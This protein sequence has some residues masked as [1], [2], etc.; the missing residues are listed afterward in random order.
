MK[1]ELTKMVL[2]F[3][4]KSSH[5]EKVIHAVMEWVYKQ[6]RYVPTWE[7][8]DY[9]DFLAFFYTKIPRL[10]ERYQY[11]GKPFEAYL[12]STMRWQI[13]NF[14]IRLQKNRQA[15]TGI[16][17]YME[18]EDLYQQP[19]MIA[20]PEQLSEKYQLQ[21]GL[22]RT[23]NITK[24]GQ[25]HKQCWQKRIIFLA[26]K[27]CTVIEDSLVKKVAL[28]AGIKEDRLF[29]DL[30]K[31]KEKVMSR[32]SR[33]R[34]LTERHNQLYAYSLLL[35]EKIRLCNDQ[36]TR[37]DLCIQLKKREEQKKRIKNQIRKLRFLP[38]HSEISKI[39]KIPKGTI[40]SSIHQLKKIMENM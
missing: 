12:Y 28:A 26:L 29:K 3:R 25:L 38:S 24:K 4:K 1:S 34:Q 36:Q 5:P 13:K 14:S 18:F 20:E 21:Q 9:A 10:I 7:E 35:H 19:H 27:N 11:S 6:P 2:E 30:Q 23:L 39:M 33:Y 15:S 8:D 17:R 40:D 31:L 22:K 32:Q 37:N 16:Y